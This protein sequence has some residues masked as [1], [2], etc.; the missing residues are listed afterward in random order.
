[1]ESVQILKWV[2]GT[3]ALFML[4]KVSLFFLTGEWYGGEFLGP[5]YS[6][7]SDYDSC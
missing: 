5:C 2:G 6:T 3:I 4:I 7:R 1:M